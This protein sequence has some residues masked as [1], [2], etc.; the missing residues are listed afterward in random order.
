M[1][2][3]NSAYE[4]IPPWD[5]GRPQKEFVRLAEDG[6]ISRRVHLIH[7]NYVVSKLGERMCRGTS[8]FLGGLYSSHA[9]IASKP[10][11]YEVGD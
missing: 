10:S 2:F 6:E 1:S 11:L 8:T 3:F 5:I 7:T 9:G 4:G